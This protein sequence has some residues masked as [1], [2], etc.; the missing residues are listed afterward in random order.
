MARQAPKRL[1]TSLVECLIVLQ[2]G[3]RK[4][5]ARRGSAGAMLWKQAK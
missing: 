5:G 2:T 4:E 3:G 1:S